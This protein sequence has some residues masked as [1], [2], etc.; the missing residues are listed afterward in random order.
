MADRQH[1]NGTGR[2]TRHTQEPDIQKDVVPKWTTGPDMS[3]LHPHK[4]S[5]RKRV[6]TGVDGARLSV[7]AHLP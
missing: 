6:S 3:H 1:I 2:H 7:T 5:R 4:Y